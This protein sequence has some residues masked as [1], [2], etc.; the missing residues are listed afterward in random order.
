MNCDN[1]DLHPLSL[2]TVFSLV[3]S[4]CCELTLNTGGGIDIEGDPLTKRSIKR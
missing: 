1:E 2:E 3:G 4:L